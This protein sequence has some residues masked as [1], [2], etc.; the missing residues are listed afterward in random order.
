MCLL[1]LKKNTC[2]CLFCANKEFIQWIFVFM[3]FIILFSLYQIRI[4]DQP[5]LCISSKM[6]PLQ[7]NKS[8]FID[9]ISL[10]HINSGKSTR[11]FHNS[12]IKIHFFKTWKAEKITTYII[13]YWNY[14]LTARDSLQP[15]LC[16]LGARADTESEAA[17]LHFL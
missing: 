6:V 5:E 10:V 17:Q 8:I 15:P 9:L 12:S 2:F 7:I 4:N 1:F 13:I 14:R 11:F 3:V 16:L